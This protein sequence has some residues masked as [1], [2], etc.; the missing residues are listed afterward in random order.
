MVNK[1]TK[2][3]L[4]IEQA[5]RE[6]WERQTPLNLWFN[7]PFAMLN[8][9]LD[10][11]DKQRTEMGVSDA[12][13]ERDKAIFNKAIEDEIAKDGYPDTNEK[14]DHFLNVAYSFVRHNIT[15]TSGPQN[16]WPL[17]ACHAALMTV[18]DE[19]QNKGFI[20]DAAMT[21][22][23]LFAQGMMNIAWKDARIRDHEEVATKQNVFMN[24][25]QTTN[26]LLN[27]ANAGLKVFAEL[28]N[29]HR[30]AQRERA[31]KPRDKYLTEELTLSSLILKLTTN[32]ENEEE[33]AK[34]IWPQL[35]SKLDE[36]GCDPSEDVTSNEIDKHSYSFKLANGKNSKLMFGSFKVMLSKAQTKN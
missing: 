31:R 28:G 10:D 23:A 21:N 2:K 29:A 14:V 13:F 30:E 8:H 1:K 22:V 19:Q 15:T 20:V 16:Y 34:T 11:C 17:L 27:E 12:D 33:S 24:H 32:L 7:S 25:Q 3:V 18:H 26:G 4:T 35:F 5:N 9:T 36:Y 6:Y